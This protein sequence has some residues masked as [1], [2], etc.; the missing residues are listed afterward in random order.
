MEIKDFYQ[1]IVS[2]FIRDFERD[3]ADIKA[4]YGAVW[5]LDSY[6]SHIF[7]L[8]RENLDET[9]KNDSHFKKAYLCTNST[10]FADVV[11]VSNATKHAVR[12]R[13]NTVADSKEV[14]SIELDGFTA[15]FAGPDAD[16]WGNYVVV[17]NKEHHLFAPLLP[18]VLRAEAFL[19]DTLQTMR[20]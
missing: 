17:H 18:K 19:N 11:E 12:D 14:F 1:R 16:E 9:Y 7:Y 5:A 10:D 13:G 2:P 20:K 3:K 8:V 15:Y 6:A 4:A